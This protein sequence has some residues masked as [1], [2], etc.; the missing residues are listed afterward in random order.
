V[1]QSDRRPCLHCSLMAAIDEFYAAYPAASGADTVDTRELVNALSFVFAEWTHTADS[2]T[3]QRITKF[4]MERIV[5][6]EAHF[7]ARHATRQ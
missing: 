6:H 7:E 2:A 5:Q 1:P 3:R 4:L